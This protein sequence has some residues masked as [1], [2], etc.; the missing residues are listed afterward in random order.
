MSWRDNLRK[1]RSHLIT[2]AILLVASSVIVRIEDSALQR[3]AHKP[4]PRNQMVPLRH[5]SPDVLAADP[6]RERCGDVPSGRRPC[7]DINRRRP[8][9]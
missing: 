4:Q 6:K 5:A 8:T 1:G 2:V 9:D 3:E 7:P